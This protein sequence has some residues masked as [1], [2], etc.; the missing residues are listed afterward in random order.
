MHYLEDTREENAANED[1][2]KIHEMVEKVKRDSGVTKEYMK[3]FERERMLIEEG[4][5]AERANT[6]RERQRADATTKT[7]DAATKRADAAE[8]EAKDLKRI[9]QE[10]GIVV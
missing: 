3:I 10:Y 1:L 8:Q 7:A 5:E 4:R 9:L 6:E 2:K